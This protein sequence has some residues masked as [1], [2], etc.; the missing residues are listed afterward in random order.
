MGISYH[1]N[2]GA[3]THGQ[4]PLAPH[5]QLAC[6]DAVDRAWRRGQGHRLIDF[7]VVAHHRD[8]A[9][10]QAQPASFLRCSEQPRVLAAVALGV[11]LHRTLGAAKD[12]DLERLLVWDQ[13]TIIATT[14][15]DCRCCGSR[16]GGRERRGA[17]AVVILRLVG[18]DVV[19]VDDAIVVA[20]AG[21]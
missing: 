10:L 2:M 18:G 6:L 1:I 15:H 7:R 16:H 14:A 19:A 13:A 8:A 21:V 11:L 3:V 17:C 4:I 5:Q 12:A 9:D 20:R